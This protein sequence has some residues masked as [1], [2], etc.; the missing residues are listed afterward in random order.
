[1]SWNVQFCTLLQVPIRMYGGSRKLYS[2]TASPRLQ[3]V[4]IKCFCTLTKTL[5]NASPPAATFSEIF[6]TKSYWLAITLP[7]C[8]YVL[9]NSW[10]FDKFPCIRRGPSGV[11]THS[12]RSHGLRCRNSWSECSCSVCTNWQVEGKC[13]LARQHTLGTNEDRSDQISRVV[14]VHTTLRTD[15]SLIAYLQ[16]IL[17]F[18]FYCG[19]M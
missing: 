14:E 8:S 7:R 1:M 19:F 16:Y 11:A 17:V 4:A 12:S 6:C 2:F 18:D 3:L 15:T 9:N 5:R 10:E 13:T